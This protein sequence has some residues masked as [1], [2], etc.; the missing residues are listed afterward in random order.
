MS[1]NVK[2]FISINPILE[3]QSINISGF[4]AEFVVVVE[5]FVGG[6]TALGLHPLRHQ[7]RRLHHPGRNDRHR[8]GHLRFDGET[9]RTHH[10]RR[11]S[12]GK[13]RQDIRSMS[14]FSCSIYWQYK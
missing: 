13:G 3:T 5:G 10:R 6:E 7:R 4:R 8:N 12:Q 2:I 1:F 9:S 14:N 11:H